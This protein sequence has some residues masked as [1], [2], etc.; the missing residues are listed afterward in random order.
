LRGEN[1]VINTFLVYKGLDRLHW[2]FLEYK[3][4][5][6][7]RQTKE[8]KSNPQKIRRKKINDLVF[9]RM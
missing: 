9:F 3:M 7:I 5:Y 8:T 4:A 2:W 1:F 6:P